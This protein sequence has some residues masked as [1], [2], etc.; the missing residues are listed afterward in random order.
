MGCVQQQ[1]LVRSAQ[2]L[3]GIGCKNGSLLCQTLCL[4]D[5]VR[6]VNSSIVVAGFCQQR[7]KLRTLN[8]KPQPQNPKPKPYIPSPQPSTLNRKSQT[9]SPKT[10]NPKTQSLEGRQRLRAKHRGAAP[11]CFELFQGEISVQGWIM[12][13]FW[14][15]NTQPS[16]LNPKLRYSRLYP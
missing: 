2:H 7:Q 5:R 8:P 15:P 3:S 9:L 4:H 13:P 6:S 11:S 12:V 1:S 16:T 14:I 10:L